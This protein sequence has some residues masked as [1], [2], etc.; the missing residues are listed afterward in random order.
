MMESGESGSGEVWKANDLVLEPLGVHLV[1]GR[2]IQ[3]CVRSARARMEAQVVLMAML[4]RDGIPA[5]SSAEAPD[6]GTF[7]RFG[8][9][10]D[11]GFA[12]KPEAHARR[13]GA[14]TWRS[15]Q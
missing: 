6:G 3:Q 8:D 13:L 9:P 5:L 10:K 7:S 4:R 15:R 2:D 14:C 11:C 12:I 1:F